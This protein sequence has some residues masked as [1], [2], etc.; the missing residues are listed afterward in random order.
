LYSFLVDI[1]QRKQGKTPPDMK[2]VLLGYMGCGKSIVGRSLSREK[3]IDHIDLDQFIESREGLSITEIF[4]QKGEVYF[5]KK[6][7][8]YLR[9]ILAMEGSFILS[10]G[11]GTPCYGDAMTSVR[12]VAVAVYLRASTETLTKRLQEV[13]DTRPLIAGIEKAEL[14]AYIAKQLFERIPF[15]NQA[16]HSVSVDKKSVP[17][18]VAALSALF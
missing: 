15:Y 4:E 2:M 10:L 6:E 12:S 5:R 18:V 8:E 7:G 16:H 11:G 1:C 9:E 14:S 13:A 17:E 3:G